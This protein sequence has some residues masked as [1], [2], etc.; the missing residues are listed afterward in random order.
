MQYIKLLQMQNRAAAESI[1]E[2]GYFTREGENKLK[3]AL[4][5]T[6]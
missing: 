3:L 4:I 6:Q 2:H 5:V 1:I